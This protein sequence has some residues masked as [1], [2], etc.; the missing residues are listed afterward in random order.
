VTSPPI[1]RLLAGRF[2]IQRQLGSGAFADVF[3][4]QDLQQHR[5]V[6]L[7]VLRQATPKAAARAQFQREY[8]ALTRLEHPNLARH[9]D[10]FQEPGA[11]FFTLELVE[12]LDWMSYLRRDLGGHGSGQ[13][14]FV[15]CSSAGLGR[16][17]RTLPQLVAGVASAHAAGLVHGDLKPDNVRVTYAGRLV[18]LDYG[19]WAGLECDPQAALMGT[20]AYMAPEQW[21]RAA[22]HPA[23]DWYAVGV[24]LFQA[25]TGAL[26]FA[27]TGEEVLLRKRS[28]N[29]PRASSVVVRVP[30]DLDE[31]CADLL[32]TDPEQRPTSEDL[33]ERFR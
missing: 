30:A 5:L 14:E 28:V 32:R 4:A 17:R 26:P 16:L 13:V 24:M 3:L 8:A 1:P 7:K 29:A 6:A 18:V 20:P 23:N 31:L 2:A 22:Q 11:C 33:L 15:P 27:G 9:Y 19:L 25:L 12:G 10:F 21:E